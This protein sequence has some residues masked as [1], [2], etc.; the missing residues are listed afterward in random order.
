[1]A[2]K[3]NH[4]A[5]LTDAQVLCLFERIAS[6]SNLLAEMCRE[7]ADEF[8]GSDVSLTFH[9][10]D[11]MLRGVGALADMP[12]GGTV[13]GDFATWMVGPMFN[14]VQNGRGSSD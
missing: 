7:K 12:T 5:G 1:M 2:T 3:T 9:A 11:T 14:Q 10:M 4:F 8:G 13:G 6:T